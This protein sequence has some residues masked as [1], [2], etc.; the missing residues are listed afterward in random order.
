M[1]VLDIYDF[2]G[3]KCCNLWIM[4]L[5]KTG[6]AAAWPSKCGTHGGRKAVHMASLFQV[7]LQCVCCILFDVYHGV[8]TYI[9]TLVIV[10]V[11]FW[12]D[13]GLASSYSII[14]YCM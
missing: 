2:H 13:I 9:H 12:V 5:Y 4:L 3:K 1:A 6:R 11:H 8:H 10:T 14:M 7:P